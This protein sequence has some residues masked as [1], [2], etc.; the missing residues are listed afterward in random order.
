MAAKR[1]GGRQRGER[2]EPSRAPSALRAKALPAARAVGPALRKAHS[3]LRAKYQDLA[4]KYRALVGPA[5]GDSGAAS[6]YVRLSEWAIRQ[7]SSGLVLVR[8]DRIAVMNK[9]FDDLVRS[10][11]G[12][13]VVHGATASQETGGK[14]F[15]TLRDIVTSEALASSVPAGGELAHWRFRAPRNDRWVE[16]LFDRVAREGSPSSTV[17]L[18]RD[19]TAEVKA[20]AELVAAQAALARQQHMRAIGELTAGIV[21]DVS[22]TLG[23]IRLRVSALRRDPACMGAQGANIEALERIVSDGTVM[24]QKLQRLGQSADVQA[25]Q[26]VDLA[27]NI[28]SAIEL[29]QSGLRYRAIHDGVDIRIEHDLP[30]LPKIMAWPDD[31]Q[32]VFVNL[33]LNARDAMPIGGRIRISAAREGGQVAIRVDDEGTGI[34]PAIMP[35]IFEPY[36][37]TKGG[38]GTGMGLA[39]AQRA[40]ARLGGSISAGN[41]PEGGARFTLLFPLGSRSDP[42]MAPG[43]VV[44]EA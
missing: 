15:A 41:R 26:P 6:D 22:N 11:R 19:I 29:A 2:D 17:A 40:M 8:D 31:L 3:A 34:P 9:A 13:F 20:E 5:G 33:L 35:R 36:F 10:I 21:H 24:L 37:T 39:T 42:A 7:P 18:V 28:T 12:P 27:E 25:P 30:R 38:S 16:V 32:R 1:S 4:K 14:K 44:D 23:A 43:S